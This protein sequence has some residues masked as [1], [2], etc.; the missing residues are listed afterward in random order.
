MSARPRRLAAAITDLRLIRL[1][2]RPLSV[3]RHGES[4]TAHF[5]RQPP[6]RDQGDRR[7]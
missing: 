5:L 2:R 4:K 6:E 7:G 3:P 1:L